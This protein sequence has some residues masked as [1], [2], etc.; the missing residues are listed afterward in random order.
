MDGEIEEWDWMG[1]LEDRC[2]DIGES[3][4]SWGLG[5]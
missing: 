2:K 1:G 5:H 4:S 3:M